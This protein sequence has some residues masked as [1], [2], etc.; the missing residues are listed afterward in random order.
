[1]LT[2]VLPLAQRPPAPTKVT[3]KVTRS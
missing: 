1:M 2:I 3:I